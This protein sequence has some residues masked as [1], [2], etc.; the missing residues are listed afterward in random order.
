MSPRFIGAWL[1]SRLRLADLRSALLDRAV[2][3]QLSWWHTLGSATL[4]VACVQLVT[5]AVLATYYAPSPDHAY[6]SLQFLEREVASGSLLRAMHRWGA[7]FMVVLVIMHMVRVFAMGAYKYPREPNWLLGVTLFLLVLAFGF[8]GY[9]LPWDQRAYFATEVGTNMGGTAP[10]V[11]PYLLR[12]LRGGSQLGAATLTRFYAFHA[13]WLPM[14]LG[15][16][17]VLHL[18]LV[19]RQGIA[20][21]P[22]V[23]E[24]GAPNRT[25]DSAYPAY[26]DARYTGSKSGA[27]RFWPHIIAKD[28]VVAAG[29]VGLLVLLASR[30]GAPLESPA[31]PTDTSYVPVPEWYFL[32]LYQLLK[33]FPGRLE[34]SVALGVPTALL[35]VLF[36][37]PLVDRNSR[38]NLRS[39][40]VALA[41]LL[42][43]L[44]G[45]GVLLGAA[46]REQSLRDQPDPMGVPLTPIQVAGRA[47][48]GQQ[49]CQSC[50]LVRDQGTDKGPDLT[51][52]G[53]RH[54]AAWLHSY[55]EQ[56]RLFR[57]DGEMPSFGPP[58][59]SHQE[60]E[61]LA[62][63]LTTLRGA[64][65]SSRSPAIADTF[66]DLR[67]PSGGGSSTAV[68]R[69]PQ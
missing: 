59:L 68:R 28:L 9:L 67:A 22:Q 56:P 63:Y 62:Q 31:D 13:I 38:R 30:F 36:G 17:L 18:G 41:V 35:V 16:L 14:A 12:L 60:V 4:T 54:S 34:A 45:S 42:G 65:G 52:V 61:Q 47:V 44:G 49:Q 46:V 6:S 32:P 7:S 2:P 11:G 39:R 24:D 43:L 29:V 64:P 53:L 1:G 5:G 23:L 3:D 37:L 19:V 69:Q 58:T 26:Y 15:A 50:H 33:L 25:T 66:P 51:D 55:L 48:F 27:T 57:P 21:R 40:P 20:P 10:W 8:T